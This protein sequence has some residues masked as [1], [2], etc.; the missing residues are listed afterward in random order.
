MFSPFCLLSHTRQHQWDGI[1]LKFDEGLKCDSM[2]PCVWDGTCTSI[3]LKSYRCLNA[4]LYPSVWDKAYFCCI[5]KYPFLNEFIWVDL[6][7]QIPWGICL[8]LSPFCVVDASTYSVCILSSDHCISACSL[9]FSACTCG[10]FVLFLPD[11]VTMIRLIVICCL[12]GSV[13]PQVGK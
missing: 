3:S 12:L 1:S 7:L 13:A 2:K 8:L 5:I 6:Y 11:D 10:V 4:A 9:L